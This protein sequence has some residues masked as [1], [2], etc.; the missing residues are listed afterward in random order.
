MPDPVAPEVPVAGV[1]AV[2]LAAG[3]GSRF[4]GDVHK[5]LQP[6]WG[7]PL[8]AWVVT[9]ALGAGLAEVAV[10][11][12]AVDLA[13][14]LPEGA[15]VLRNPGWAAGQAGSLR[16]GLD[17]CE[18]RGHHAVVV[19]LGDQPLVPAAAWRAVAACEAAPIAVATYGGRRRNPVRL[20]R[21]VWPLLPVEGDEGARVLMAARPDLVAE[22]ACTGTPLDVD[23]LEDLADLEAVGPSAL[24]GH[25]SG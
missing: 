18:R 21:S 7:R 24:L 6:L 3:G 22:V 17:W 10:V 1:A 23:T 19:G 4:G 5:L 2:V 12:G 14:V 9:A 25:P 15:V 13:P 16:L 11:E 8:V 20:D